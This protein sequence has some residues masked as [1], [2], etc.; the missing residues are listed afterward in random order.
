MAEPSGV[1]NKSNPY[2][3]KENHVKLAKEDDFPDEFRNG[4]TPEPD[5]VPDVSGNIYATSQVYPNGE[6]GWVFLGG[7]AE[8]SAVADLTDTIYDGLWNRVRVYP[9]T[10]DWNRLTQ[11]GANVTALTQYRVR[12]WLR[13]GTSG[14]MRLVLRCV[15]NGEQAIIAGVPGALSVIQNAAGD[16]T[17]VNDTPNADGFTEFEVT[18]DCAVT[19][20][21]QIGLSA[22]VGDNTLYCDYYAICV[23]P[24]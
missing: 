4:D 17:L 6:N 1:N 22:D 14:Q 13:I 15:T 23:E 20:E 2:Y 11:R 18:Y 10:A 19:D 21:L 3:A 8:A 9:N 7:N 16:L 5:P 24:A 12:V